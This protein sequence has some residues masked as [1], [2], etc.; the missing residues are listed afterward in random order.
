MP[1]APETTKG[2]AVIT[3]HLRAVSTGQLSDA[4]D[5]LALPRGGC[6][7]VGPLHPGDKLVGR[8]FTVL[9]GRV[10]GRAPLHDY[11]TLAEP[12]DVLMLA[13][14]GRTESAVW[15]GRRSMTARSRGF[16]GTVIDG[17]A[18]DVEE[19][20]SV[21]YPVFCLGRSPLRSQG[22][23]GA[24]ATGI[25]V[26]FAGLAVFPGDWIVGDA[27]GVMVLPSAR[28]DEI[29]DTAAAIAAAERATSPE[30]FAG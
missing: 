21:G 10:L 3:E 18:R 27:S 23:I 20:A 22:V 8:A 2:T 25:P 6:Y 11:L 9:F 16:A 26:G 19:H 30:N 12:G 4:M 29:V 5:R 14:G 1:S 13:A 24:V 17:L 7:P 15:G 28:I